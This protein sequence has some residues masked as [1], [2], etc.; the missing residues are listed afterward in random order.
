MLYLILWISA[1]QSCDY[2]DVCVL[3]LTE[4][5]SLVLRSRDML[6]YL[7]WSKCQYFGFSFKFRTSLSNKSLA[8]LYFAL[9]RVT[10]VGRDLCRF[11]KQGSVQS[12]I[13]KSP[14]DEIPT[15][16]AGPI[17]NL[18]PGTTYA[19]DPQRMK[20]TFQQC[21]SSENGRK[22]S[23]PETSVS[24]ASLGAGRKFPWGWHIWHGSCSVLTPLANGW[25]CV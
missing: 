3:R 17:S 4:R 25:S 7:F 1:E 6:S 13:K 5:N 23:V 16:S 12:W 10:E 22:S 21:R 9:Y 19:R 14:T 2:I 15:T 18:L 24:N 11:P 8:Y 20:G